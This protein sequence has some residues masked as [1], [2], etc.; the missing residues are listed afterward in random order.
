MS[1]PQK[2][3]DWPKLK[4]EF[5]A[6]KES[7]AQFKVRKNLGGQFYK[8]GREWTAERAEILRRAEER[9]GIKIEDALVERWSRYRALLDDCMTQAQGL[10]KKKKP[11]AS[12]LNQLANAIDRLL[13]SDS[14]L[15][16][17]PTEIVKKD[18]PA[19]VTHQMLV[20]L[21]KAV[22]AKDPRV[23]LPETIVD[24]EL[25]DGPENDI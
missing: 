3:Y 15:H 4:A 17:Q 21:I 14:L 18:E 8:Y 13:K 2:K 22:N 25:A 11:T 6:S 20:D 1:Y 16:G 9:M 12:Q 24:A 7:A 19:T 10:A 23:V 5:L